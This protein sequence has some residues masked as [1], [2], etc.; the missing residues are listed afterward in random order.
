MNYRIEQCHI[1]DLKSGDTV[2]HQ[3]RMV[4]VSASNLK[5][6]AFMGTTLVGDSYRL[7]TQPVERVVFIKGQAS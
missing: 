3:G 5:R 2:M 4:T 6:D 1:R 7:G